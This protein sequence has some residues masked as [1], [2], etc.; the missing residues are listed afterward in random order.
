MLSDWNTASETKK[1]EWMSKSNSF[2][3]ASVQSAQQK[4]TAREPTAHQHGTTQAVE[5]E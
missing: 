5:N 1:K 2:R 3:P 4:S